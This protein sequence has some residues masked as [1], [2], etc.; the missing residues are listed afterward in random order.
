MY[1]FEAIGREEVASGNSGS[2]E[3]K[4]D[5]GSTEGG[6]R[7]QREYTCKRAR[8]R[9][10]GKGVEGCRSG[11]DTGTEV[12]GASHRRDEVQIKKYRVASSNVTSAV[13]K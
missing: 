8:E 10:F 2:E 12:G 11:S 13:T 4:V 6:G 1:L 3:S 9:L 7:I 5:S